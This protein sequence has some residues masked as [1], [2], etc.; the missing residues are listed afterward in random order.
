MG[1]RGQKFSSDTLVRYNF[2]FRWKYDLFVGQL[3]GK[4][5]FRA[6]TFD[7]TPVMVLAALALTTKWMNDHPECTVAAWLMSGITTNEDYEAAGLQG[8]LYRARAAMHDP[9]FKDVTTEYSKACGGGLWNVNVFTMH[10][11]HADIGHAADPANS[12]AVE[13]AVGGI[14]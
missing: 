14:P 4:K 7:T 9:E 13:E 11:L 6:T 5:F 10:E 3:G 2:I 8:L 12:D 1:D